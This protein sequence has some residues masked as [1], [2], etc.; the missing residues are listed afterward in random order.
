[1]LAI[2]TVLILD[3]DT[4]RRQLCSSALEK[5]GYQVFQEESGRNGI[6]L[7][8]TKRPKVIVVDETL[9]DMTGAEF[10]E[11]EAWSGMREKP[12]VMYLMS[13]FDQDST[14]YRRLTGDLGVEVVLHKPVSPLEFV[15]QVDSLTHAAQP[16]VVTEDTEIREI[17][18]ESED[19]FFVTL[20]SGLDELSENIKHVKKRGAVDDIVSSARETASRLQSTAS[21]HG[22]F[23]IGRSAGMIEVSLRSAK[24]TNGEGLEVVWDSVEAA[25]SHA[26]ASSIDL[27]GMRLASG[28]SHRRNV[29]ATGQQVLVLTSDADLHEKLRVVS[30]QTLI[31]IETTDSPE[32]AL[33]RVEHTDGVV[34]DADMLTADELPV[35]IEELLRRSADPQLPIAVVTSSAELEHRLAPAHAGATVLLTKPVDSTSLTQAIYHVSGTWRGPRP[36]VLIVDDDERFAESAESAL[37]ARSMSVARRTSVE[38]ILESLRQTT[39]DAVILSIDMSGV[40][41]FDVCRMLRT[42]PRWQDLPIIFVG[43][44]NSVNTRTAAYRA[45]A[46]DIF[47]KNI[48]A[49]ELIARL[50]VRLDRTRL[51]RERADRDMLTGVLSR[52][53]FLE[54]TATRLSEARRRDQPFAFCLLDLDHFKKVNDTHGHIAGDRVLAALGRL[55]LNRFRFEDLRG[56]W[57][58]E[59][60]VV[61]LVNEDAATAARVLHRLL[62][63]FKSLK[64]QGE[65]DQYFQ[66][67]FS[68]GIAEYPRDGREADQLFEVAD[69]RLYTAKREGRSQIRH[70]EQPPPTPAQQSLR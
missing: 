7:C 22:F 16:D 10:L 65:D 24:K 37:L 31:H 70:G 41:P 14:V 11:L 58:G 27:Q 35:L 60:F 62:R 67:S 63:E 8:V 59:E 34:L 56:R 1:M 20:K 23:D 39:P 28:Q 48:A 29:A 5:R 33:N 26:R 19:D 17:V 21:R 57:G 55:L 32:D 46:D 69:K 9:A 53:A 50:E 45:G 36:T 43:E 3:D 2:T 49:E 15:V 68:A 52:R 51:T 44:R 30:E 40:A 54:L 42:M 18:R 12:D 61:G 66:V 64:F 47:E 6:E 13:I 25:L 38:S 4:R